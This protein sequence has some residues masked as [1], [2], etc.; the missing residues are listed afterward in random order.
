MLE[1]E[2]SGR[3]PSEPAGLPFRFLQ[4]VSGVFRGSGKTGSGD[5]LGI[6]RLR[7]CDL[8]TLENSL[9][10]FKDPFSQAPAQKVAAALLLQYPGAK[11]LSGILNTSTSH[12]S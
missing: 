11:W 7:V 5:C 9:H 2:S 12:L 3:W 6:L 4:K 10:S 8:G 1:F